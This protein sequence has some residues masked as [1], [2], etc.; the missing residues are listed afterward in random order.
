[1][2]P[3]LP[4]IILYKLTFTALKCGT[5][6]QPTSEFIIHLKAWSNGYS[7]LG[8]ECKIMKFVYNEERWKVTVEQPEKR[9]GQRKEKKEGKVLIGW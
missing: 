9:R 1:M 5:D 4:Q 6:F 7:N 8:D 3:S 2:S